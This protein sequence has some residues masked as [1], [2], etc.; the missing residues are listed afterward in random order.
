M[1]SVWINEHSLETRG[2]KLDWGECENERVFELGNGGEGLVD[3][4]KRQK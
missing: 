3:R 4:E 1:R 2:D